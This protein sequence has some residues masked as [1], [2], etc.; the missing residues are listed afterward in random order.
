MLKFWLEEEF[1]MS[2]ELFIIADYGRQC[3]RAY[4]FINSLTISTCYVEFVNCVEWQG[5]FLYGVHILSIV[6]KFDLVEGKYK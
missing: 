3:W 4:Y 1:E 5:I 6:W 2:V